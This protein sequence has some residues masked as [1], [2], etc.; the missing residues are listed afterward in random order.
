MM[1]REQDFNRVMRDAQTGLSQIVLEND[2]AVVIHIDA[3]MYIAISKEEKGTQYSF[4]GL[5]HNSTEGN[6]KKCKR[7]FEKYSPKMMEKW[8]A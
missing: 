3:E 7:A 1:I 8:G 2:E 4:S 5:Y 6:F